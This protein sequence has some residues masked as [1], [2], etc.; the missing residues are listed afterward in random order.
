MDKR[1]IRNVNREVNQDVCKNCDA[2]W[3]D[4]G[5]LAEIQLAFEANAQTLEVKKM[6]ER[7]E[8]MSPAEKAEYERRIGELR[9]VGGVMSEAIGQAT[10]E[11]VA[12]YY[13]RS[14]HLF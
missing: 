13:F 14:Y 12:Y 7:I 8:N 5:E 1:R 2:I 10:E 3:F 6:R 9:E 11:L 4:G